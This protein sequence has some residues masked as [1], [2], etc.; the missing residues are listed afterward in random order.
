M[1][2]ENKGVIMTEFVGLRAKC[3]SY[4]TEAGIEVKK[5]KGIPKSIVRHSMQ[6][7]DWK[8]C[9]FKGSVVRA[10]MNTFQS[11][12]HEVHS[13]SKSKISLNAYDDKRYILCNGIETVPHGHYKFT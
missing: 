9:L 1:K 8:S 4:V 7:E 5:N 10:H 2:D 12:N 6:H 13:M 3:Y 11:K